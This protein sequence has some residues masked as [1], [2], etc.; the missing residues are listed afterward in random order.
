MV[1]GMVLGIFLLVGRLIPLIFADGIT[2]VSWDFSNAGDYSLSDASLIEITGGVARLKSRSYS[3]DVNTSFLAHFN[4]TEGVTVTDSS[5]NSNNGTLN[6]GSWITGKL[7]NGLQISSASGEFVTVP[8][9]A[10]LSLT[11]ANTIEMW[12][13]FTDGFSSGASLTRQPLVDK[14]QFQLFYDNLNGK[15]TYELARSNAYSWTQRAGID[16]VNAMYYDSINDSWD[17]NGIYSIASSVPGAGS[18]VYV[19]L[20]NDTG[21]AEVWK[22]NGSAWSRIGGDGINGSWAEGIY[23]EVQSLVWDGT[24]L[25]AGT[26]VHTGDAE[27]WRW[28]GSAWTQIGGDAIYG[29]WPVNQIDSVPSMTMHGSLLVAGLGLNGGDGEVWTWD[30]EA[31]TM[32]GGDGINSGWAVNTYESV[33]SVASDGTNIYAGTGANTGDGDVWKWDGITWTQIGGDGLNTSWAAATIEMVRSLFWDGT[34]LYAGTGSGSGE[35]DLWTWNGS[36]WTQIGGDTLNSGWGVATTYEYVYSITKIGTTIYV[37]LGLHNNDAEVWSWNGSS[38]TKVGGDGENGS[39]SDNVDSVTTLT[40]SGTSLFAGVFVGQSSSEMWVLASGSWTRMGGGNVNLSWGSPNISTVTSMASYEGNLYAG[41]CCGIGNGLVQEFNGSTWDVIGGQG[42]NNSWPI[43]T[44]ESV[45]VMLEANGSLYAGLAS[46][47]GDAEVWKWSG[48]DW[49]KIGGDAENGSWALNTYEEVYSLA[50]G[51]TMLYA[52]LGSG[53]GDGEVWEWNGEA[54]N[55]I[56]GDSLSGSWATAQSVRSLLFWEGNLYAGTGIAANYADVWKWDGSAWTQIG[57]DGLYSGWGINYE[58]VSSMVVYKDALY[59]GVGWTSGEA[60]VWKWDGSA[61]TQVG[62]DNINDGW[63]NI[64]Y[65]FVWALSTYNG[66]LFAG[67]GY[68]A[69]DSDIYQYDGLSWTKVG[70]DSLNNGWTTGHAIESARSM[71]V[72][73]GKLF[74]GFGGDA[75]S[76][77]AAIW[78][79]GN[80]AVLTSTTAWQ[81]SDWHH[82]AA[83]YDGVTMKIYIDGVLDNSSAASLSM[84]DTS[85]DLLVGSGYGSYSNGKAQPFFGGAIDELRISN[86]ARTSFNSTIYSSESQSVTLG[87]AAFTTGVSNYDS[88]TDTSSN[89]TVTY[90]LSSDG[91][92][93]WK[94]WDGGAWSTSASLAQANTKADI[95]T[96]IATFPVTA[97]GIKWQAVLTGDGTQQTTLSALGL[98]ANMDTTAPSN[99]NA[100]TALNQSGGE[101][102]ILS[103]EVEDHY[104]AYSTPYFSWTGASDDAGSGVLGYYVYLG[105]DNT[106]DPLTAGSYQSQSTYSASGLTTG[107]YYLRIKTKDVAGNINATAWEP[108]VYK[109]DVAG[110]N[111]PSLISVSPAGYTATN[112]FTFFWPST[113][114]SAASDSVSGIAGYQY[115]TATDSGTYS[116]WSNTITE[117]TVTL[118]DAAYQ[119]DANVFYLRTIDNAGNISVSSMQVNF[120]FSG[121][122]PTSP[123]DLSATPETNTTNSFAFS[124]NPPDSFSGTA[125]ELTYCYT[126]NVLPQVNTCTFTAAGVTS[127]VADSFATLPGQNTFYL[128]AKDGQDNISYDSK[129]SIVFTADTS[130][131]G[132]PQSMGIA[133]VS[134]KNTSSWKLAVS[135]EEPETVGAGVTSYKVHESTDGVTYTEKATATGLAYVDTGLTQAT[136]YY[137][138][139]ACDSVNNCGAFSAAI[140]L[141]P[142]GKYTEA[143]GLSSGPSAG[144]ITTKKATVTWSTGRNSDSKVQ[145]GTK[146]ET[147]FSEEPSKSTQGTDHSIVLNSLTPGTTYFYRAKWTDEDGNTGISDEKSFTTADPPSVKDV[148]VKNI[149]VSGGLAHFTSKAASKVKVYYGKTT[150]F[151]SVKEISTS[152]TETA[153]TTELSELEDGVK[154]YYKINSFDSEDSEYEGTIL[155][156]TTLPRPKISSVRLEQV[157]NTAQTTVRVT[158]NSNTEISS[159]ITYYP[160]GNPALAQDQVIVDLKTGAHEMIVKNLFPDTDYL[161]RVRGRDKL[162]NEATSDL[163]RFTTATDTRPPLIMNMKIVGGTIPP[164]GF[165]AGEIK[166]QLVVTWDSDELATSQ[167]EF[168]E[169][170]GATYTQK[171]QEDMNLTVNHAVIISQLVPSRVYH[172]RAISKDKAGNVTNSIDTV[173]IAPKATASAIDLVL[174][175]LGESFKFINSTK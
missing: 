74:V 149:G 64:T 126:V 122:A 89:G 29:S 23:E 129:A 150:A 97:S 83:S 12:T 50:F 115:K 6:S 141:Y 62:G 111:N 145:Y 169:G 173:V 118:A 112:S 88:M 95:N 171:S 114:V 139:K 163:Q 73:G 17:L 35:G 11:Q 70:G 175:N 102:T 26:G 19:G 28:N 77:D 46:G 13:K 44:I 127:L 119:Q 99:P 7:D 67:L 121:S 166:A 49:V 79:Y 72:H 55:K 120:Y 92:S 168:G 117:T 9:S 116:D 65:E 103:S 156:F 30:G 51:G 85:Q 153:Y 101:T 31:W 80:N 154:Y 155:D 18:D 56:G 78:S 128:V 104:Y 137:K 25:Y 68:N 93:T 3:S 5:S 146:S 162:G 160:E 109:Y 86:S 108:F 142:D 4:E 63:D 87:S 165:A 20:G 21:D 164:V 133:D 42:I 138:V 45:N 131:P 151:G 158:W 54:W 1:A 16:R 33:Y 174:G 38:W 57:G 130:A 27:V 91:G 47:T 52:G 134:V 124:W 58:I 125:A 53:N 147:Y 37:G 2:T 43:D 157:L 59:V 94:Y 159:I 113:G 61:W 106:A 66:Y 167:V 90:R 41:L 84:L 152:T 107:T 143:A 82:V 10:P 24:Y 71:T 105:T 69:N 135:W 40:A 110:P 34:F 60:E 148:G 48:G 75:N 100:L 132:I 140:S 172:L 32:I 123:I 39:W 98:S 14:G 81:D 144:S 15:I 36:A 22:W 76:G 8:D 136:H 170:S 161:L 96:N